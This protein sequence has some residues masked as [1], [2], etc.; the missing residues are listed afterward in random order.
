[1]KNPAKNHRPGYISNQDIAQDNPQHCKSSGSEFKPIL[2]LKPRLLYQL[3]LA[4]IQLWDIT[5]AVL[6]RAKG[7]TTSIFSIMSFALSDMPFGGEYFPALIASY[8]AA[9]RVIARKRQ[10]RLQSLKNYL[11]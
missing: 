4:T 2:S 3:S 10:D 6:K 1:V 11:I 5:R 9:A 8:S 7:S